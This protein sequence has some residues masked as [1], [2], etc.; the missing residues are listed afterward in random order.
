MP[1]A[2]SLAARA[3]PLFAILLLLVAVVAA[4]RLHGFGRLR[5]LGAPR[6]LWIWSADPPDLV[7]PRAFFVA[8]DFDLAT[9]PASARLEVIGD[10]EYVVYLG[11][12]R[13]GSG[14]YEAGQGLDVYEVAPELHPGSNRVV[15]ELRSPIGS[16]GATLRIVDAAGRKLVATD[17][18]WHIYAMSW[19]GLVEGQPLWGNGTAKVLGA[20]PLGRWGIPAPTPPRPLFENAVDLAHALGGRTFQAPLTSTRWHR[21]RRRARHAPPLGPLVTI[22]FGAVLRGYLH[23]DLDPGANGPL[24]VRY[25]LAPASRR[26]WVPDEVVV[27]IANRSY[28][29]GPVPRTFRF[30]EIAGTSEVTWAAVLPI[31]PSAWAALARPT[32]T[33]GLFG[34]PPPGVPLP[35]VE[36]IWKRLIDMPLASPRDGARR[37]KRGGAGRRRGRLRA[38]VA[39]LRPAGR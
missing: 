25:G 37:L 35:V 32:T 17:D 1:E 26:G 33:P 15:L 19:K 24:L 34:I 22:D 21:L 18:H 23:L 28:W 10:P 11:G 3:R 16:G 29:Q 9:V 7:E 13:I 8:R 27:P 20:S 2:R 14:S 39:P 4:E 30:V 38:P 31:E 5:T 12:D 36:K 6:Q